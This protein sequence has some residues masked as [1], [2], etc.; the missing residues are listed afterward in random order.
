M[1]KKKEKHSDEVIIDVEQTLSTWEKNIEENKQKYGI[2]VAAIVLIIGAYLAYAKLYVAPKEADAHAQMFHA[3]NYFAKD[4]LDKAMFGDGNNLGFADIIEEYGVTSAANLAHY[5]MGISYLRKGEFENAITHLKKFSSSDQ[6][7]G[8]I[9][10][11]AIGD[12]YAELGDLEN[13][14]D[15]YVKAARKNTNKFTTPVYLLRAGLTFEDIGK[16]SEAIKAYEKIK[17][18]YPETNEGRE[19]EKYLARARQASGKK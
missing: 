3:E 6:M 13:A 4:S 17:N 16:N 1:A 7:L 15:F 8:P 19:I 18:D 12:A 11:G 14:A 5:Y 2:I 10:L 9:S